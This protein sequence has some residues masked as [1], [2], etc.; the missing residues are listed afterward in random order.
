[1]YRIYV[2]YIIISQ[3]YYNDTNERGQDLSLAYATSIVHVRMFT[4]RMTLTDV[5]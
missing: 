5:A 2:R 1:M 3:E 4:Y